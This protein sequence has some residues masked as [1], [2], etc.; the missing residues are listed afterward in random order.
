MESS[1]GS[2]IAL[3]CGGKVLYTTRETLTSCPGSMLARMFDEKTWNMAKL[4]VFKWFSFVEL[5]KKK[6]R[7]PRD[8]SGAYLLDCDA[9]FFLP[10]LNFLRR[11]ELVVDSNDVAGVLAEAKFFGVEQLVQR[12]G[13]ST[14]G[15][16]GVSWSDVGGLE[17][18]KRELQQVVGDSVRYAG[19]FERCGV[20]P[21]K[22]LLLY[23]PPGCGK[24][25]LAKAAANEIK[26]NFVM[27]KCSELLAGDGERSVRDKFTQAR[28]LQPC[29]VY[30]EEF[31]KVASSGE[32]KAEPATIV[33][34]MAISLDDILC[35]EKVFVFA[36]TNRPDLIEPALLRPGRF[37]Q[38]IYVPLPNEKGRQEI[39]STALSKA[40]LDGDVV[41]A[42]LADMT[43]GL[44]GADLQEVC[45][46][47]CKFAIRES[48]ANET[49]ANFVVAREHF[50]RA[51]KYARPS[52]AEED[53]YRYEHFNRILKQISNPSF[54]KVKQRGK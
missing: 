9:R 53:L 7:L 52:V 45:K 33:T 18:V 2:F 36:A 30:L 48:I 11:G 29:V 40:P 35:T 23:G 28:A 17:G 3:N 49:T 42:E 32:G 6:K 24:T 21:S 43:E 5:K 27:I 1:F 51:L 16:E 38:L 34:Q 26:A 37:D 41:L 19:L 31:E 4:R 10:I 50:E 47:A 15:C 46:R 13:G 25:L 20:S 14:S 54:S 12:L 39:L 8:S 44:S 22:N